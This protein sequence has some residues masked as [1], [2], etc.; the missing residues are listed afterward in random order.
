MR[1]LGFFVFADERFA[2]GQNLARGGFCNKK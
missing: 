1:G 2:V